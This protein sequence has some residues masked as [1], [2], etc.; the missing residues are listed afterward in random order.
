MEVICENIF[1]SPLDNLVEG[2]L[3]SPSRES[4]IESLGASVQAPYNVSLRDS[5]RN[6]IGD[7]LRGLPRRPSLEHEP[8]RTAEPPIQS[9]TNLAPAVALSLV[10]GDSSEHGG[11][12]MRR[13]FGSLLGTL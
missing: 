1:K 7:S 3:G 9:L 2:L 10:A 4:L 6:F 8:L 13:L 11:E 12:A 5:L